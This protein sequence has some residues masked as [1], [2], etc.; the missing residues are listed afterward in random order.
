MEMAKRSQQI[1]VDK[2]CMEKGILDVTKKHY[3]RFK[4][5]ESDLFAKMTMQ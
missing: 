3:E 2:F 1:F 5:I 4:V